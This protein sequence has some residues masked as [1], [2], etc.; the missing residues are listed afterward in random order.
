MEIANGVHSDNRRPEK[1]R[2]QIN[3]DGG[4]KKRTRNT[5]IEK[6]GNQVELKTAP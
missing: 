1:S 6:H 5:E 3:A 2:H 4:V